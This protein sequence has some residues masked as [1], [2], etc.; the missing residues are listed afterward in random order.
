MVSSIEI[1]KAGVLAHRRAFQA[2]SIATILARLK[3]ISISNTPGKHSRL[4]LPTRAATSYAKRL[5]Q[6]VTID[7]AE[8]PPVNTHLCTL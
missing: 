4:L 8:P 5:M 1:H 6:Y 2:F 7:N 3:A